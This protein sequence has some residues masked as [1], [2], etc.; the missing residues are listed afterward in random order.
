MAANATEIHQW[1]DENGG[2]HFGD[3][4]PPGVEDKIVSVRPN[5]YTSPSIEGLSELFAGEGKVILYSTTWCE[6]CKR[7]KAYFRK[8]GIA[9]TEYDVE[10][11]ARGKRDYKRLGA[12]GVPVILVGKRRMNGFSAAV[13]EKLYREK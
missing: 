4:P 7:A 6:Y 10:T 13:F 5:V 9:Y 8:H 1:R 11:S 3:R 12:K 2:V